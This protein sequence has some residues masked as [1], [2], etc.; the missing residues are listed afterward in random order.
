MRKEAMLYEQL[1]RNRVECNLCGTIDVEFAGALLRPYA[2]ILRSMVVKGQ[3]AADIL[4][5][6]RKAGHSL[7]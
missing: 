7:L 3:E 5:A 4:E 1:S 6:A 2:S